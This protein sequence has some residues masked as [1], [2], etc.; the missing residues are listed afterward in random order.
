MMALNLATNLTMSIAR[1]AM[2]KMPKRRKGSNKEQNC[3]KDDDR[4]SHKKKKKEKQQK[5]IIDY[6]NS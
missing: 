1:V 6:I 5:G 2:R 3:S 4:V